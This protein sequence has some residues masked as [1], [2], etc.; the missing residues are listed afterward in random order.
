M[1]KT[2]T[3]PKETFEKIN[4]NRLSKS[5][6]KDVSSPTPSQAT[7]RH[8]SITSSRENS[9]AKGE[10]PAKEK[11]PAKGKSPVIT[12]RAG[13]AKRPAVEVE[14]TEDNTDQRENSHADVREDD[15]LWDTED[16]DDEEDP[17]WIQTGLQKAC[18]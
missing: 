14:S 12:K 11:S 3:T 8:G 17:A 13:T 18:S 1:H 15:A 10:S 2:M 4:R 16:S 7:P 9:P 6:A 5:K